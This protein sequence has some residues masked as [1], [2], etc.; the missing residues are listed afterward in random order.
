MKVC[1]KKNK[2]RAIFLFSDQLVYAKP[3]A[4]LQGVR[5]ESTTANY[6]FRAALPL[7]SCD[8]VIIPQHERVPNIK[9]LLLVS[10]CILLFD[11][12]FKYQ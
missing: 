4:R 3:R 12:L 8:V 7:V 6:V 5:K 2:E 11:Y 10:V 1:R 9:S